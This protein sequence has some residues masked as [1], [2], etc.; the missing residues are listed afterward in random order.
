V[1]VK[2]LRAEVGNRIVNQVRYVNRT[3]YDVTS[4]LP[5]TTEGK[6]IPH[7]KVVAWLETWGTEDEGESRRAR[8]RSALSYASG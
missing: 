1:Q 7:E 8:G 4:K 3:V 2:P 5:G 6:G